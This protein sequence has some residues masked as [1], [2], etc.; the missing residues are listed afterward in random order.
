MQGKKNILPKLFVISGLLLLQTTLR[1]QQIAPAPYSSDTL[2]NYIR[3][4]DAIIP[5]TDAGKLVLTTRGD[6]AKIA[7]QYFDGLGRVLQTV[8]RQGSMTTGSTAVDLVSPV[9]Y[10]EFGREQYKYLPFAA[11]STGSNTSISDG[12]FKLNPFQQDSVFCKAQY[13]DENYYY[14]KTVF[15]SSPMNRVQEAYAAGDNWVGTA[16]QSSESNRRGI[17]TKY[18]F[19]TV[20]DS[21]RIWAVTDVTNSFGTYTTSNSYI[22]GQLFKNVTLDE[23]NN[24]IIEFKDKE[25]KVILKKVQLTASADTSTGKGYTGWLCTYYIYD[26]LN[27]LRCVIQPEGVEALAAGS[28]S[29]TS[30]LLDEQCFR[31]EYDYRNRMSMKK[32]PGGGV[33]WMVYDSRNRLALSQDSLMRS[34]HE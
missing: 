13:S 15:E 28:W 6:S 26:N 19:N 8:L 30:T 11:N 29:L 10:D 31:Y 1:G 22:A 2:I 16:G 32:V 9:V 34:N 12:A 17:K 20:T 18:W 7:T 33:A 27:N 3:T 21:V 24:Q 5:M 23:N 25:G 14:N 4:W